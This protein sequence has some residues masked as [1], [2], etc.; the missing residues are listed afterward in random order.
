MVWGFANVTISTNLARDLG[1]RIVAAIFYGGDAFNRYAPIAV[2]VN[3]PATIFATAVYE[4]I[5]RDSF[6]II[7]KGMYLGEQKLLA[8]HPSQS[9]NMLTPL[10]QVTTSTRKARKALRAI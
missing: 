2:F 5:L 8:P 9:N 3:V 4:M 1:T 10:F 7:A 6:A